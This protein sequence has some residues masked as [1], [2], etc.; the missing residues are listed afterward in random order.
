MCGLFETWIIYDVTFVEEVRGCGDSL[1]HDWGK[2][3]QIAEIIW[4]YFLPVVLITILDFRVLCCHSVW[5]SSH[6]SLLMA[7]GDVQNVQSRKHASDIHKNQITFKF[8]QS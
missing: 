6:G 7:D 5:S 1:P 8:R 4:S 2:T 3:I